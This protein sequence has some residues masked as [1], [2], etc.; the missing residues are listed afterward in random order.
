M[1]TSDPHITFDDQGISNHYWDYLKY[2]KPNLYND[3]EGERLLCKYIDTIKK[4]SKGK[5]FDCILGLSGGM[6]SSYML[7]KMV[8][9][10]NLRP[11]VFHVDGGWNT[12]IAVSNIKNLVDKLKLDLF[13]EV[14]DWHE[15]REFQLA[16]FK[17]GVPHLDV[18]Q[19]MAF[20]AVLYKF[21]EKYDVKT[22]LNGGNITTESVLRPFNLIYYGGDMVQAKDI[23][24]KFAR[25]KLE[26]FPF[27]SI[28]YK[29]LWLRYIRK[30]KVFKPLNYINYSK[31]QATKELSSTYGWKP[32]SQ[33]HFESRFTR[34]Y[35]GY[36]LLE[37]FGFDMRRVELS[38]LILAG[39]I[40][41][42]EALNILSHP[43]LDSELVQQEFEY[44]AMK[45]NIP[46]DEL[47]SYFT[48]PKKYYWDYSN[49]KTILELGE[50][51]LGF[52]TQIRRGGAY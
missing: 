50:K 9:K 52:V 46:I 34:F 8:T 45:L 36:W 26:S 35:E 43:P 37:R 18:P 4:K 7:H 15:M 51:T 5:D 49:N 13:T 33:K 21:A 27:V 38:S 30:I 24:R 31:S 20:F 28:I 47:N 44:V 42:G 10:Y 25:F 40:T 12:E 23:L 2:S 3:Q 16:M 39:Q 11:L 6:D 19:D 32:Y 41:R 29:K 48:M 17:S 1:D 22:I 14:I